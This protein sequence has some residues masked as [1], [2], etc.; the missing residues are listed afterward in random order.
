MLL[1]GRVIVPPKLQQHVV[2]EFHEGHVGIVKMKGLARSYFWWPGLD[3]K[4]K[5]HAEPAR[6]V[7][8]HR[9][10]LLPHLYIDGNI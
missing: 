3:S 2:E 8:L 10:T 4:L 6:V 7:H 9:T 5:E 1:G